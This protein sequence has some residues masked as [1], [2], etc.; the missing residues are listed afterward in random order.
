MT[1]VSDGIDYAYCSLHELMDFV[2]FVSCN[3]ILE[4]FIMSK[5]GAH[6]LTTARRVYTHAAPCRRQGI[7]NHTCTC[8]YTV[9]T[10]VMFSTVD[11]F[12][13]Q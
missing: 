2:Y 11:K 13:L 6:P 8:T 12:A 3:L 9:R 1:Q 4:F 7:T 5:T 10:Y